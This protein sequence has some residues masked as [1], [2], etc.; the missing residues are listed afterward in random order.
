MI[1][2]IIGLAG[3]RLIARA[4]RHGLEWALR[5]QLATAEEL[6]VRVGPV[7]PR[8][9]L[10][11]V[12][13]DLKVSGLNFTTINGLRYRRLE[14][15]SRRLQVDPVKLLISK[16]VIWRAMDQSRLVVEIDEMALN[17]WLRQEYPEWEPEIDFL[18][19][20]LR[21]RG[22]FNFGFGEVAFTSV[23]PLASNDEGLVFQPE[24]LDIAGINLPKRWLDKLKESVG[25]LKIPLRIPFPL[26]LRSI[27]IRPETLL[28]I[29]E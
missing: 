12:F 15:E 16:E 28:V 6:Q 9:M 23:G 26:S 22:R 21:L 4:F 1:G 8:D 3:P 25:G 20:E 19:D 24:T 13:H 29:W 14:F 7:E 17:T 5:R 18:E 27:T 10:N 11:G 2:I